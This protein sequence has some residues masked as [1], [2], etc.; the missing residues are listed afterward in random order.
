M[1]AKK[2][3]L[4]EDDRAQLTLVAK[5]LKGAGYEVFGAS[6]G[7]TAVSMARKEKPDLVILDLGLPAGDGFSVMSRL[8]TLIP[9]STIPIVVVTSREPAETRA[10]ALKAG[11]LAY[12]QK[13]LDIEALLKTIRD[14]LGEEATAG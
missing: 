6:D 2:I 1:L 11:A 7:M 12:L 3:L 10:A 5:R 13:P 4:V 9:T 8:Q 14:T